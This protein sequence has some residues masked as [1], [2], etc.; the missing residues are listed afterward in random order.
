MEK[1]L[2]AFVKTGGLTGLMTAA[3]FFIVWRMIVWIMAWVKE[4]EAAHDAERLKWV[5]A[6]E[7]SN[8]AQTKIIDSINDHDR[9]ADERGKFVRSEHERMIN[10]LDEQTKVLAH[11]NGFKP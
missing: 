10:N 5:C 9:R 4:R 8:E 11:I 7:K 1:I 2:E 3:L 6:I